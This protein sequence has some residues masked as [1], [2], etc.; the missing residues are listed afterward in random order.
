MLDDNIYCVSCFYKNC[1]LLKEFISRFV[2]AVY[3]HCCVLC[4]GGMDARST[5]SGGA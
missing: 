5:G 4:M 1:F 2:V 3:I